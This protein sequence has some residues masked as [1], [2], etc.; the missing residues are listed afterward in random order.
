MK[1]VVL[2]IIDGCRCDAVQQAATPNIDYLINHGAYTLDAK[3]VRPSVT[4]PVHFSIF[5][6]TSPDRHGVT[7]NE[8][9]FAHT[10]AN[11]IMKLAKDCGKTTAAFYNWSGLRPLF[12]P[13]YI[14]YALFLRNSRQVG[15][16]KEIAKAAADHIAFHAPDLCVV[17]LGGLDEVGHHAGFMSATYLHCLETAD[18]AVG[19]I[20]EAVSGHGPDSE[21]DLVLLS[22]HGGL[23]KTH[24][25]DQPQNL[26]VPW[27]AAGPNIRQ[28]LA[29]HSPVSIL[30]TA[31]TVAHLLGITPPSTW[32]GRVIRDILI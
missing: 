28:G 5:T 27:M 1:K 12:S 26:T 6:S 18:L 25:E 14:D 7:S 23:G 9:R 3:T 2:L 20:L 31:P 22:D 24:D 13:N 11:G 29:I 8:C 10:P 30:D 4:L 21:Y 19:M 32:Q 16:D 15:G 17:Y